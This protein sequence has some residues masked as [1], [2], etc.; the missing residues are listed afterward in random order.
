MG[1]QYEVTGSYGPGFLLYAM[2]FGSG[3]LCLQALQAGAASRCWSQ[4]S[5]PAGTRAVG[6]AGAS[7]PIPIFD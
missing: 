1:G 6:P 5:R 4:L 3:F 2:V 7:D